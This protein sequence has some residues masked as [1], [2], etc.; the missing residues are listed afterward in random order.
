MEAAD[1]HLV[2]SDFVCSDP[3]ISLC[4]ISTGFP[5]TAARWKDPLDFS[6]N[7]SGGGVG[8]GPGQSVGCALA[9]RDAGRIPV[10]M[11]GDGDCSMGVN[12]LWTASRMRIPMLAVVMNNRSYFNDEAHQ[13]HVA[14]TRDRAPE[15]RWIGLRID[16]PAPDICGLAAAQGFK[17]EGPVKTVKGLQE[18][19]ARGRK[20]VAAGG[21]YMIDAWTEKDDAVGRRSSDG[22]RGEGKAKNAKKAPAKKAPAKKVPAKKAKAKKAKAKKRR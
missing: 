22:G 15:N 18:A 19:L 13:H 8:A 4:H 7:D 5:G 1:F 17:T 3:K 20:I 11:L 12:A 21:R 6:G 2:M 10:T 9:Y 14:V 16:D